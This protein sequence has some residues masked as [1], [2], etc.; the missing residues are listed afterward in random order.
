MDLG[1]GLAYALGQEANGTSETLVLTVNS[2]ENAKA[3][4]LLGWRETL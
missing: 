3:A 2:V 4:G 1:S